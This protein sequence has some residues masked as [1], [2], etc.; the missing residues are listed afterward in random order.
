ME[1]VLEAGKSCSYSSFLQELKAQH[2]WEHNQ[3]SIGSSALLESRTNWN[4]SL[5]FTLEQEENVSLE[6]NR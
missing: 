1:A 2:Y 3:V 4:E 6:I 5:C